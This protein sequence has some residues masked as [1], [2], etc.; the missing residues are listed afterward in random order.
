MVD[1][2]NVETDTLITNQNPIPCQT[3]AENPVE[4]DDEVIATVSTG[5]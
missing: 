2:D 1:H 3:T 4:M 5:M